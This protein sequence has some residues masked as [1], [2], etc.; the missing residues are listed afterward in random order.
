MTRITTPK[1]SLDTLGNAELLLGPVWAG[2]N[3]AQT[4]LFGK[5]SVVRLN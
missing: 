2:P 5:S 1:A 4:V 3:L